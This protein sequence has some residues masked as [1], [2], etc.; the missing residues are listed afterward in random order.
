VKFTYEYRTS[1]NVRHSGTICAADRESAFAELKS[2]GIR[3]SSVA[4][5]PGFFNIVFGKGKRWLAIGVLSVVSASLLLSLSRRP[6]AKLDNSAP[7][8]PRHFV[9]LPDGLALESVFKSPGECYLATFALHG[10]VS[11]TA[12]ITPADLEGCLKSPILIYNDD[13]EEIQELKGIVSGMKE[14]LRTYLESGFGTVASYIIRLEERQSMEADYRDRILRRQ[15]A[16]LVAADEANAI[17]S[18]MGLAPVDKP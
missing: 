3:P 6:P 17:L 13:S 18:A 10:V 15:K 1:D 4:E 5:A 8:V 7:P 16:G 2:H 11:K 9:N 14:D 12:A